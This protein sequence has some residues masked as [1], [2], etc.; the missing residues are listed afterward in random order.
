MIAKPKLSGKSGLYWEE[1]ANRKKRNN[2]TKAKKDEIYNNRRSLIIGFIA[3]I[4]VERQPEKKLKI[5]QKLNDSSKT[6]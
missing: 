6:A 4:N 2:L 5:D 1:L 3:Q